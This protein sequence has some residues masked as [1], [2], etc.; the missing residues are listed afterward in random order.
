[1]YVRA[2]SVQQRAADAQ[3]RAVKLARSSMIRTSEFSKLPSIPRLDQLLPKKSKHAAN[4][5]AFKPSGEKPQMLWI[6]WDKDGT[7]TCTAI[8]GSQWLH[9][10]GVKTLMQWCSDRFGEGVAPHECK[11]LR[12]AALALEEEE[13]LMNASVSRRGVR[14]D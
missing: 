12:D 10:H 2:L 4:I 8:T 1:M 5:R 9:A 3:T 11:Q 6:T 7:D 13:R 14:V